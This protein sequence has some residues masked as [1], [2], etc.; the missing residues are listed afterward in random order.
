MALINP[1]DLKYRSDQIVRLSSIDIDTNI[2][3]LQQTSL[4]SSNS[5]V[6]K[7]A[8]YS[9]NSNISLPNPSQGYFN[10]RTIP[11]NIYYPFQDG[12][13]FVFK[14]SDT[15]YGYYASASSTSRWWSVLSSVETAYE[16]RLIISEIGVSYNYW[17]FK[18]DSLIFTNSTWIFSGQKVLGPTYSD[19]QPE[20]QFTIGYSLSGGMTAG[21]STTSIAG[22]IVDGYTT[23][24]YPL[25]SETMYVGDPL[26]STYLRKTINDV[27]NPRDLT[28]IDQNSPEYSGFAIETPNLFLGRL[29][30]VNPGTVSTPVSI[31]RKPRSNPNKCTVPYHT[32]R[33]GGYDP[34]G[35]PVGVIDRPT[36]YIQF[37]T[38]ATNSK[39]DE[40]F[41]GVHAG[42]VAVGWDDD[43]SAELVVFDQRNGRSIPR[44]SNWN[45]P[46]LLLQISGFGTSSTDSHHDKVGIDSYAIST[47]FMEFTPV[48]AEKLL[49]TIEEY[50]LLSPE[51]KVNAWTFSIAPNILIRGMWGT[52]SG[53]LYSTYSSLNIDSDSVSVNKLFFGDVTNGQS[54]LVS[55]GDLYVNDVVFVASGGSTGPQGPQGLFGATGPQGL[56]GSTGPQGPVGETGPAGL[57]LNFQGTWQ[58]LPAVYGELEYVTYGGSTWFTNAAID[59]I[60]PSPTNSNW[61][62]FGGAALIVGTSIPN[63]SSSPGSKGEIRVDDG[64]YLYI[65]T[66]AQW[67]KSSMTFS[68][69]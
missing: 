21:G 48:F 8:S 26:D 43:K 36:D 2:L 67:L 40:N 34:I 12:S 64:Q 5:L 60:P 54:L 24:N 11:S 39:G 13:S 62:I 38:S 42:A 66:G 51:D 32:L 41:V 7:S 53:G 65:H 29:S 4:A 45:T 28:S 14:F 31:C 15:D 50:E 22:Q 25:L 69:F 19:F 44:N 55:G 16:K 56:F 3:T 33:G 23:L 61:T 30:F 27:I 10:S 9:V 17:E 63:N 47:S 52:E 6:Y 20:K 1:D 49:V 37:S 68:T 57:P 18:M 58:A 35:N 46:E 59:G